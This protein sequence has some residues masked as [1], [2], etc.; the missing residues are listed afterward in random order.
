MSPRASLLA[1]RLVWALLAFAVIGG[2]AATFTVAYVFNVHGGL[3]PL[4]FA[5]A[6]LAVEA[7]IVAWVSYRISCSLVPRSGA[8][9]DAA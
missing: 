1:L 5:P 6:G 2:L 8:D 7:L 4:R 9:N 3:L